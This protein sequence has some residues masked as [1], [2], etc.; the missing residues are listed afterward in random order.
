MS[1]LCGW[2]APQPSPI[3]IERMAAPISR[4][5][6][7][8]IKSASHGH[9]TVALSGSIDCTSLFCEDGLIVALWGS[10][11]RHASEVAQRWR[12]HGAWCCAVL[13]GQFAFAILDEKMGDA[14]L[15]VD[16]FA[17][18]P[19]HFQQSGDSLLFSTCPDAL[20][21]HPLAARTASNSALYMY[22]ALGTLAGNPWTGQQQLQPGECV[23]LHAGRLVRHTWWRMRFDEH[24][25]ACCGVDSALDTALAARGHAPGVMLSGGGASAAL[26]ARLRQPDGDPVATYSIA[27][28]SAPDASGTGPVRQAAAVLG[29]KHHHQVIR[30]ADVVDAIPRLAALCGTPCGDSTAVAFYYGALLARSQGTLRLFSG[31]GLAELYGAGS[32]AVQQRGLARLAACPAILRQLVVEPLLRLRPDRLACARR[33]LP[34][35]L[36]H[37]SPFGPG[38]AHTMLA[39]AFLEQIDPDTALDLLRQWW[40]GAQC[41]TNLNRAIVLDL[42]ITLAPRVA[43]ATLGCALAGVDVAFPFLDDGVADCAAH[44][45]PRHKHGGRYAPHAAALRQLVPG[46]LARRAPAIRL[47]MTAW[48]QSDPD[49]RALAFD[50]LADLRRRDIVAPTAIDALLSVPLSAP[51]PGFGHLVWQLMM[52]EQWFV[53]RSPHQMLGCAAPSQCTLAMLHAACPPDEPLPLWQTG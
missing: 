2:F 41:R 20:L 12:S 36:M 35:Q 16:R 27:Y 38:S 39:P 19:L 8:P 31:T 9:G 30:P 52:L 26:A 17:T 28:A 48:L 18:R 4:F 23:H 10:P 21:R 46:I 44:A 5:E 25:G 33:D 6:R 51:P 14:L 11:G 45:D 43:A 29:T 47:P 49:L 24:A 37:A 13:S 53:H 15:A 50:S 3:T 7:T 40:W 32:L 22:L 34:A 1:G 42:R